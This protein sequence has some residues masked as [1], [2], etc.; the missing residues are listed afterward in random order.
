MKKYLITAAVFL[1][2]TALANAGT[3][4]LL[5]FD[6]TG[7]SATSDIEGFIASFGTVYGLDA[8]GNAQT[9][10]ISQKTSSSA[11]TYVF[12]PD[13]NVQTSSSSYGWTTDITFGLTE[14]TSWSDI[15]KAISSLNVNLVAFNGSGLAQNK[16]R[17]ATYQLELSQGATTLASTSDWTA[18]TTVR[19]GDSATSFAD[20]A[21][22]STIS[23]AAVLSLADSSFNLSSSENLTLKVSVKRGTENDGSFFGISSINFAGTPIPE[24]STFGLLAGLGALALA[25]TRRRRRAK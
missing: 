15:A 22:Y 19:C 4:T 6:T 16:D 23:T 10:T 18:F 7:T 3:E 13:V 5:T 20:I 12:A 14:D 2:G 25:G 8:D 11:S 9:T 1:T 17:R 21:D 24:P